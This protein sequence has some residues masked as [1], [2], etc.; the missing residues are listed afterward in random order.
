MPHVQVA[1]H[2]FHHRGKITEMNTTE[3]VA[4]P[5]SRPRYSALTR[6]EVPTAGQVVYLTGEASP[7][8]ATRPVLF[9]VAGV[10]PSSVDASRGRA[11]ATAGWLYLSGWELDQRMRHALERTVL[12]RAAG[13]LVRH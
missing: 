1:P 4:L 3:R 7:Q 13:L 9:Q 12:V 10:E 6:G 2:H 11:P 5:T 8:F